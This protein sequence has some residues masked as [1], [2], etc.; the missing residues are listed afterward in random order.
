[1]SSI[2]VMEIFSI[3]IGPSSS[4]TVGPM[5]AARRF[6]YELFEREFLEDTAKVIVELYGSLA[7][8]GKGHATD[9]A[10]LLGLEGETPEGVDPSS[11]QMRV[12]HIHQAK[13]LRLFGREEIA[14][15]PD[16]H[17][18][19][20][21]G[22][23]LPFHSNALKFRAF[24]K[25][26]VLL[27]SQLYYSIGGGFIIDQEE[28]IG[29]IQKEPRAPVA[30][31]YTTAEELLTH[32]K[33]E[34]K[35]IWEIVLQNERSVRSDDEI[36][37][38]IFRI[39]EAMQLSVERGIMTD[40]IL[41]GGLGVKRRAPALYDALSGSEERIA[42]DPTLVME[43][44]SLFALAVNEENAA[45]GRVVTAPT[46]GSAGVIPA[47]LHYAQKFVPQFNE[48]A[49]VPFFLTTTAIAILFKEGASISAAEMGCQGEIGVSS[50]MAAAGLA[51]MLGASPEQIANAAE[52][53]MEHHLGLTCDPVAG[54]VQIP[55]IER[56]TMGAN[57]AIVAARLA[58]RGDG[59]HKV[60]LDAVIAAM[61]ETGK[62][63][64][65]IYKET[66]EGGLALQ[67]PVSMPAC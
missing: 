27:H 48:E 6:I 56:N 66:S 39:W 62:N 22:K 23:R 33:R 51:S 25:S 17:L 59:R 65:S 55:C 13:T 24:N 57:K 12:Q 52:I 42:S 37:A 14:F 4:H 11:V 34:G 16:E 31:P 15:N 44:V 7:M 45:G 19:F 21:R 10:V 9:I 20:L 35:P 43:W 1:M 38:G 26:G 3:G 47:V 53:A 32:C 54:L 49:I 5:R 61:N 64:M 46:N 63:M 40:G 28:A 41:P 58:L 60:S 8:T 2:S 67:I 30:F 18:K 29:G 36:Y 50:A